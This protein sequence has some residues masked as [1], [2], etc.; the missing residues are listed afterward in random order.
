MYLGFNTRWPEEVFDGLMD[1]VAVWNR[2]L[3][4]EEIAALAS[5]GHPDVSDPQLVAYFDGSM[6]GV[7]GEPNLFFVDQSVYEN[8]GLTECIICPYLD[9]PE[10]AAEFVAGVSLFLDSESL[11]NVFKGSFQ[12]SVVDEPAYSPIQ[13][14]WQEGDADL[15]QPNYIGSAGY[16]D[17][18]ISK[19]NTFDYT[20]IYGFWFDGNNWH[21]PEN[22]PLPIDIIPDGKKNCITGFDKQMGKCIQIE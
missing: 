2:T 20:E 6:E 10:E 13:F 5:G 4:E 1:E 15:S 14:Y 18:D 19:P 21:G 8:N 16:L 12:N 3:S 17:D 7:C 9:N 11:F 22:F